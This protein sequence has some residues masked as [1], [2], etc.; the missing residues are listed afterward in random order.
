MLKALLQ[1]KPFRHPLHPALVH[2]PIGLFLLSLLLDIVSYFGI[3]PNDL[4]RA[5]FYAMVAGVIMG[6]L[7][8]LAGFADRS[9]IRLDHPARKTANLHMTLNLAVLGLFTVNFFLRL[10]Q[11]DSTVIVPLG[12][13]LLSLLGVGIILFSGYLGGTMVYDDGIGAGRHRRD[14]RTPQKTIR[15]S[16]RTAQDGWLPVCGDSELNDGETLRVV[17]DGNIIA[18]ARQGGEVYAFQEFCTHRYGPLSEGKIQDHQV[19]CPWHRSCFDIR[20]GKVVEGPAKLDL[21]TYSAVIREGK[22]FIR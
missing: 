9:G 20:T 17:C 10:G 4:F 5:S 22:I 1:G 2:F 18:I 13:V 21:K 15:V 14:T 19:V 16:N 3:L 8:V 6:M 7:A 12:Y 11:I